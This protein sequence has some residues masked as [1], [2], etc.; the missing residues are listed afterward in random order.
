MSGKAHSQEVYVIWP[1]KQHPSVF[2]TQTANTVFLSV[3][4]AAEF[5]QNRYTP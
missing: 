5:L 1:A 2:I 4:E 3:A